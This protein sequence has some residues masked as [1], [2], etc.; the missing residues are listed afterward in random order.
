MG[1][2]F[3]TFSSVVRVNQIEVS[4]DRNEGVDESGIHSPEGATKFR[5]TIEKCWPGA[6]ISWVFSWLAL[7]D[8]RQNYKRLRELVVSYHKKYGDEITFIPGAYFSPMYNTREQTN[9][10]LHDGL[11]LV[12]EMVGGRY[13]PLAIIGGFM[14]AEN[15]QYLAEK[16]GIHVCQG[17]IWSQYAV[18]N[19]DGEG[20][21]SYPY[22]PSREHFCKPAQGKEDMIDCVNLDG[23]TVDFLN[24][25]YPVPR[26]ING[27]RCG[28]RQGV[29]PIE[30]ILRQGIELGTKEILATTAAHFDT[31][32]KL[33]NF[34]WITCIWELSLVEGRNGQKGLDGLEIWLNEMRRR[35]PETKCITHG[36]FGMLWR[37]QFKN[38]DSIN[39]RFVQRGSGVC[40]SEPEM[41]IRWFMNKDF[42]LALLKNWQAN[43]PEKLID[44]TR[45]DLKAH[46]PDDPKPGQ[47]TRNWSLMNRLNQKGIRPQDKPIDIGQ[48]KPDEQAIIEL[49]YPELLPDNSKTTTSIGGADNLSKGVSVSAPP[50]TRAFMDDEAPGWRALIAADFAQV[51]SADNTWFWID[52]VLHCTGQPVSVLRTAKEFGN[53]EMVVE[54]M[55]EKSA[56]NSGVFVWATPPSIE[57]LTDAGKPGLP[58]GIEVQILDHGFTDL[59]KEKGAKTDWFGTNGDVFPVRVKMTPFPPLSPDGSRS[60]PRKKLTKG[61]GEWN[62][63]YIRAINGEVRLWV[64]GEEVSGG[65]SVEPRKGYLCLESEG[66]PIQF[67]KL[68]VRELP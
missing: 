67:R 34:A 30:T 13:R 28:S 2:R 9:R 11:Q 63:Y 14:S 46:E 39:Y 56:G 31:G 60:F 55:H 68:R 26:F 8:Q 35:W 1:N 40:G 15:L 22:Y 16:E 54:W 20:S 10:D 33:N 66:S 27:I 4:R 19:G 3:F 7:N 29:G 21:I 5:E 17:N 65:T 61:H 23:W 59:M 57:K 62:H 48:L 12:S 52:S 45:Y 18:D 47:N 24:A 51:N 32:F 41:E 25:R 36:E 38:N 49:R 58:D 50:V 64:N 6:R 37:K 42:R 53:F 44:F 43:T